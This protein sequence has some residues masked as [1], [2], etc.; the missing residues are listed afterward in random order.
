MKLKINDEIIFKRVF[1]LGGSSEIAQEICLNLVKKGTK[2]IHLICRNINKASSFIKYISKEFGIQISCQE[3]DLLETNLTAK[4]TID[5]Y[6][7]YII[8]AGYLENSRIASENLEEAYKIARVNYYSL[9][10]WINAITSKERITKPGA[11]WILS[12][13]AGD[14]GRPSNFHYGAAKAALTTYCEG[15]F[16]RCLDKPFK[17]RIIK[18]GIIKTSMSKEISPKILGASKKYLAKTLIKNPLKDG[19]EYLPWF[20]FVIMKIADIMPKYLISKL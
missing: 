8:A 7:L 12:S 10:P 1:V 3:L 6:D 17:V 14:K 20:W 2:Q 16:H 5:F 11:I 18:A 4:P 19:I 13:V 9:I 15:I